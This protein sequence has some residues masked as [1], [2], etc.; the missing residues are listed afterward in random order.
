[1]ISFFKKTN[2]EKINI[3]QLSFQIVIVITS[4]VFAWH[5]LYSAI[6]AFSWQNFLM[7]DYGVYT[8]TLYNLA[9]GKGFKFLVDNNYLRTH[10]SFSLT[11]LA[12]LMLLWDSVYLL[13]IVQWGFLIWGAIILIRIMCRL[14]IPSMLQMSILLFWVAYPFTQSVLL[15]EF[16]GVASYLLLIPWLLHCLLFNKP[17]VFLPW[18]CI[19]G[20][21]EEA[22]IVI[23]PL[24]ICMAILQRWKAGY[25]YAFFSLIY[26]LYAIGYLYPLVNMVSLFDVVRKKETSLPK[27]LEGFGTDGLKLKGAATFWMILPCLPFLYFFKGS[28]LIIIAP[29][30]IVWIISMLSGFS[31]QYSLTFH[32]PAP[33]IALV[34]SGLILA[35]AK[36]IFYA[37]D[38]K[39]KLRIIWILSLW[40][41]FAVGI[42]HYYN[43]YFLF[44]K[45]THRVYASMN[46]NEKS[47]NDVIKNIP[48]DGILLTN[49][50]LGPHVSTRSDIITWQ[51]FVPEKHKID[52][53]LFHQK[54]YTKKGYEYISN[55]MKSGEFKVFKGSNPYVLLKRSYK[56]T[57]YK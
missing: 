34:M 47:L 35:C 17:M 54:E 42:A 21:R 28:R 6:C 46:K 53:I 27:I 1:M 19:L 16:H 23:I 24:F 20:V 5:L 32:Y 38:E 14:Q 30:S 41:F 4:I 49:M 56:I 33:I 13:I 10:L 37:K 52:W 26:V 40:V 31:K 45:N 18:L 22:G 57:S 44:G 2:I 55:V 15:Y 12:P 7:S 11:L 25:I 48:K 43:G 3:F 39:Q 51:Y 50:R 9:H 29:V 36:S 8:N